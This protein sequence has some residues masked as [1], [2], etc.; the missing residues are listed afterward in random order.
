MATKESSKLNY[1]KTTTT[2]I[3]TSTDEKEVEEEYTGKQ[4]NSISITEYS[5]WEDPGYFREEYTRNIYEYDTNSLK[6]EYDDIYSYLTSD[7]KSSLSYSTKTEESEKPTDN[8]YKENK[9]VITRKVQN[10]DEYIKRIC[11]PLWIFESL[12]TSFGVIGV[13][14]FVFK[15]ISK[16]KLSNIKYEKN[17]I[18]DTIEQKN[19]LYLENKKQISNLEE[20]LEKERQRVCLDYEKLPDSIKR[21]KDINDKTYILTIKRG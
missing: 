15:L 5:P 20:E 7:I 6:V 14:L 12:M 16:E 1:Y 21:Q 2:T 9:Y 4:S 18:I 3:D 17:K 10:Q 13:D 8:N 19:K 11:Y